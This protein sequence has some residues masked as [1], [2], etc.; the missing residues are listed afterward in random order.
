MSG[1]GRGWAVAVLPTKLEGAGVL[2]CRNPGV[3]PGPYSSRLINAST[4][5]TL[6]PA[7]CRTA[8]RGRYLYNYLARKRS[9]RGGVI[10][11]TARR[12]T[13][14]GSKVWEKVLAFIK[15]ESRGQGTPLKSRHGRHSAPSV[16]SGE[17]P[18]RPTPL[19]LMGGE[20]EKEGQVGGHH[21][22]DCAPSKAEVQGAQSPTGGLGVP[23]TRPS[24]S[25]SPPMSGRGRGWAVAVLPTK[26]EGAGVL[27]CRDSRGVP[28]PL[29]FALNK[30]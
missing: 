3:F 9:S 6:A 4:S 30:R 8:R 24:F 16:I 29:L 5:P 11:A 14:S 15:R 18:P 1:R 2:P 20:E 17:Q 27:P 25:S 28:W 10:A 22:R 21:L 7:L 13:Q 12:L 23:P 19:P 26:L